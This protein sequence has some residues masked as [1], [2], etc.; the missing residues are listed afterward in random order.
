MVNRLL[1]DLAS[2]LI[3]KLSRLTLRLVPARGY[4]YCLEHGWS[5]LRKWHELEHSACPGRKRDFPLT[6]HLQRLRDL[7]PKHDD[8]TLAAYRAICKPIVGEKPTNE[9][10]L[11]GTDPTVACSPKPS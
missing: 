4:V 7:Q 8:A 11:W 2:P 6:D 1:R 5:A 9:H 10:L 3:F